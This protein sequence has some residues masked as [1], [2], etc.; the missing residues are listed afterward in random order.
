M[1]NIE[2]VNLAGHFHWKRRGLAKHE[3]IFLATMPKAYALLNTLFS[4]EDN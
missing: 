4:G 3:L 2:F 1:K